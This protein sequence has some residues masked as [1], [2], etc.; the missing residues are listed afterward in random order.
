MYEFSTEVNK[1]TQKKKKIIID[2]S[3]FSFLFHVLAL[4]ILV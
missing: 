1:I 3:F 2:L 4:H